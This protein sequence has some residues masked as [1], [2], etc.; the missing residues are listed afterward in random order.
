MSPNDF[1][2]FLEFFENVTPERLKEGPDNNVPCN[3]FSLSAFALTLPGILIAF[4]YFGLEEVC[5]Q[6]AWKFRTPILDEE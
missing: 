5:S 3:V 1:F 6:L 4:M 2:G